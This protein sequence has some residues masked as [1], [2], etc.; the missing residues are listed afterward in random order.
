MRGELSLED[1]DPKAFR[2]ELPLHPAE[3]LPAPA[4]L[5][6]EGVQ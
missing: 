5:Q 4:A 2:L 6:E 1:S 3:P